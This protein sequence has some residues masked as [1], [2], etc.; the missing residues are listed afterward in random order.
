MGCSIVEGL[1]QIVEDLLNSDKYKNKKDKIFKNA[2]NKDT[3]APKFEAFESISSKQLIEQLLDSKTTKNAQKEINNLLTKGN[4]PHLVIKQKVKE[5]FNSFSVKSMDSSL[6]EALVSFNV[7]VSHIAEGLHIGAAQAVLAL[8][9]IRE[10]LS[11]EKDLYTLYRLSKEDIELIKDTTD[12][13]R[14]YPVIGRLAFVS[15]GYKLGSNNKIPNFALGK[16]TQVGKAIVDELVNKGVI[17]VEMGPKV[18]IT[19]AVNPD[20]SPITPLDSNGKKFKKSERQLAGK[21]THGKIV[22][23]NEKFD[24]VFSNSSDTIDGLTDTEKVLKAISLLVSPPSI[25]LPVRDIENSGFNPN[26]SP[27]TF[28]NMHGDV[29]KIIS[30]IY[31]DIQSRPFILSDDIVNL[32]RDFK[33][34]AIKSGKSL[35]SVVKNAITD[36]E[37]TKMIFGFEDAFTLDNLTLNQDME[38]KIGQQTSKIS[39][40]LDLIDNIDAYT[41]ESGNSGEFYLRLFMAR[42]AR[43]H[44]Y[45]ST[46]NY[47]TDKFMS[48]PIVQSAKETKYSTPEEKALLVNNIAEHLNVTR[49]EVEGKTASLFNSLVEMYSENKASNNSTL[50]RMVNV[51]IKLQELHNKGAMKNISFWKLWVTLDAIDKVRTNNADEPIITN[52]AVER[53]ASASGALIKLMYALGVPEGKINEAIDKLKSGEYDAYGYGQDIIKSIIANLDNKNNPADA[54]QAAQLDAAMKLTFGENYQDDYNSKTREL[55][56]Y[57]IMTY[58]YGQSE[59]NNTKQVAE[60]MLSD[61]FTYGADIANITKYIGTIVQNSSGNKKVVQAYNNYLALVDGKTTLDNSIDAASVYNELSTILESTIGEIMVKKVL[62]EGYTDAFFSTYDSQIQR[63][64]EEIEDVIKS[65]DGVL[66]NSDVKIN[67]AMSLLSDKEVTG[68]LLIGLTKLKETLIT[69]NGIDTVTNKEHLNAISS[70]VLP[71]HALDSAI[72]LLSIKQY[73][74]SEFDNDTAL[75]LIHD[76]IHGSPLVMDEIA[77]LYEQNIIEVTYRY[78]PRTELA[79]TY[80]TLAKAAGVEVNTALIEEVRKSVAAK[81]KAI[82]EKF[83]NPDNNGPKWLTL[84]NSFTLDYTK[85]EEKAQKSLPSR[86]AETVAENDTSPKNT[87]TQ[88]K[89]KSSV[90]KDSNADIEGY[91]KLKQ[92]KENNFKN[93]VII[94]LETTFHENDFDKLPIQIGYSVDGGDVVKHWVKLADT[95]KDSVQLYTESYNT[96]PNPE[97]YITPAQYEKGLKSER[98]ISQN[99]FKD[100]IKSM[101]DKTFIGFN[102]ARFDDIIAGHEGASLDIRRI[103]FGTDK[104][105]TGRQ[106]DL[107]ALLGTTQTGAHEADVDVEVLKNSINRLYD[108]NVPVNGFKGAITKETQLIIDNLH[109]TEVETKELQSII[110]NSTNTSAVDSKTF[111]KAAEAYQN[112]TCANKA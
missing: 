16:Y 110:M 80:E 32:F 65:S 11:T 52:F 100:L 72:L 23:F 92:F 63:L 62:K 59:V 102:N 82:E 75:Q 105:A 50:N 40:L 69:V 70:K 43:T 21:I 111:T 83:K 53:D 77:K 58:L 67:T 41:A 7:D 5:I 90:K 89:S 27:D 107:A 47:Q 56:K 15:N 54:R 78:D 108:N 74:G 96:M 98:S 12:I 30:E 95:V 6:K 94:D 71:I 46:T 99:E 18:F 49:G 68:E 14:L 38:S 73:L 55:L 76:A 45:E 106:T 103:F 42:N 1:A 79:K 57:A 3:I 22:R 81:Q 2:F 39:P 26:L 37:I 35:H 104:Y 34:E 31:S 9:Q 25:K 17:D 51:G 13:A 60:A 84:K 44:V 61:I 10:G 85:A 48:R 64:E 33:K 109:N 36:P 24:D 8:N 97:G 66:S 91:E 86:L 112:I 4:S 101:K 87:S 93:S 28:G 29:K 88:S 19:G 20:G